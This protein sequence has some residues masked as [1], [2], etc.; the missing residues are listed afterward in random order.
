MRM[1]RMGFGIVAALAVGCTQLD[2]TGNITTPLPA[3]APADSQGPSVPTPA[4]AAPATPDGFDFDGDA[5]PEVG[6]IDPSVPAEVP[7]DDVADPVFEE[8][9]PTA[10]FKSIP[11]RRT[12]VSNCSSSMSNSPSASEVMLS[13]A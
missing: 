9:P 6:E 12:A 2:A 3:A 13:I 7:T 4:P 1:M 8:L 5:Q 10:Q 11:L